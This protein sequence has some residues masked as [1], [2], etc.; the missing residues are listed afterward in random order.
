MKQNL[1]ERFSPPN[2][3]DLSD[4]AKAAINAMNR[5]AEKMI[6]RK[7]ALGHDLLIWENGKMVPK[8]PAE[9]LRDNPHLFTAK[10]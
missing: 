3:A 4:D 10:P 1:V 7:I 9:Y 6:Q 8:D 5:A 2:P